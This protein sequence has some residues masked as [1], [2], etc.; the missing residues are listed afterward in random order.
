VCGAAGLLFFAIKKTIG[1]RVT[2]E[3]EINGLDVEEH[4]SPGYGEDVVP[5]LAAIGVPM[6]STPSMT[7]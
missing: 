3:E 6:T 1:L 5:S 7:G 2:E 4:G